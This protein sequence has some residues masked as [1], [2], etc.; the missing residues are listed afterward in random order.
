VAG[1][2]LFD[3]SELQAVDRREVV[4]KLTDQRFEQVRALILHENAVRQE[5]MTDGIVT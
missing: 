1:D 2:H 4:N 3:E 5:S